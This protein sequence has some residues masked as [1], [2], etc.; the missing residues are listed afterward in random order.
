MANTTKQKTLIE[1]MLNCDGTRGNCEGCIFREHPDCRNAM[2]RHG[3]ALIQM[4]EVMTKNHSAMLGKVM[5]ERDLLNETLQKANEHI[6]KLGDHIE[7]LHGGL[8]AARHC[9]SCS[10]HAEGANPEL[11]EARCK[12][13][14]EKESQWGLNEEFGAPPKADTP[15]EDVTK[16]V[17]AD[18]N[19]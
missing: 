17:E 1:S 18:E 8:M 5:H 2:A 10:A 13:C 6:E 16:A 3:G 11:S 7:R 19:E 14:K 9:D 15:V 4:Q 12:L